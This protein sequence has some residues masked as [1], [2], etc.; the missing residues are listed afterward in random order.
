MQLAQVA[1][2]RATCDRRHVGC[3][4]VKDRR[5]ISTGYNASIAGEP[6]CD[7]VGH[8]ISGGAC[9]RALHAEENAIA[10]A[11]KHGISVER[12]TAYVTHLPCWNC[13]RLLANA[14]IQTIMFNEF[15][16][17]DMTPELLE[18]FFSAKVRILNMQYESLREMKY[19]ILNKIRDAK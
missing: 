13:F 4:L 18:L 14:G 9:I 19:E 10:S 1:A 3:V 12:S 8:L 16:L 7:D 5:V 17:N 2:T 15:K 11:A 6:H